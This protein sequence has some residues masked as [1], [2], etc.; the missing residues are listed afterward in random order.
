[1]YSISLHGMEDDTGFLSRARRATV[2][3]IGGD[4]ESAVARLQPYGS[5]VV[6]ADPHTGRPVGMAECWLHR[7]AYRSHADSPFASFPPVAAS[8]A[9]EQRAHIRTLYVEPSC[10]GGTAY[11]SLA[12]AA[13]WVAGAHGARCST[14]M[15]RA[16]DAHL[17]RLYDRTGG[18]RVAELSL[19]G[20]SVRL[21]LYTFDVERLNAHPLMVRVKRHAAIDWELARALASR[22]AAGLVER[23]DSRR[24][25]PRSS[26]I[27]G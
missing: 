23:G 3:A 16:G 19:A 20:W 25:E 9:F 1:M 10:R 27:A 17:A 22:R 11:L 13:A 14:M 12:L 8:C 2:R 18:R 6:A 7:Q 24:S 26:R 5:Y 4:P 15:T 21:A